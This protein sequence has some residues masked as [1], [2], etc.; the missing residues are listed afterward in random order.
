MHK[1]LHD[2]L[3]QALEIV[4]NFFFWTHIHTHYKPTVFP[5]NA[6]MLNLPLTNIQKI[7]HL[8]LQYFAFYTEI[9]KLLLII[10]IY[11]IFM[12]LWCL[13]LF[14]ELKIF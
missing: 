10:M 9:K 12:L 7:F 11:Y 8:K 3:I 4:D 6:K 1:K 5:K 14:S 13:Y 2:R